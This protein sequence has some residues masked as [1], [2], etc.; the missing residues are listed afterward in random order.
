M[1]RFLIGLTCF[2]AI[3]LCAPHEAR[4]QTSA[5]AAQAELSVATGASGFLGTWNYLRADGE[6]GVVVSNA[7]EMD[8]RALAPPGATQLD[9]SVRIVA[10]SDRENVQLLLGWN[11]GLWG[12][13]DGAEVLANTNHNHFRRDQRLLELPLREG[14]HT[15]IL[16]LSAP[17]RGDW[18]L[19]VRVLDAGGRPAARDAQLL[20]ANTRQLDADAI[21]ALRTRAFGVT[22]MRD[23]RDDGPHLILDAG[24]AAGA[25]KVDGA[26]RL[27]SETVASTPREGA[28]EAPLHRDLTFRELSAA[29]DVGTGAVTTRVPYTLQEDRPLIAA[30]GELNAAA[31]VPDSARGPRAWRLAELRRMVREVE[32]DAAWR[33]LI[34]SEAH[35][36]ARAIARGRN[37]FASPR[38]YVRMGFMSRLDDTAQ[39]YEL[40]VPPAYRD[41]GDRRWPLLITLHGHSGNAGDYFRNTF[42]LSR[43][44]TQTLL[45]HGR[46][47]L[48]PTQGPM[49]V[50]A[51]TGRGQSQY[52]YAGEEDILEVLADVSSRFRI[53]PDRIYITGGSMGGTGAAYLPFRHP[54]LFAASAALAGYH[55]Q[56]VR[57]DTHQD[58]LAPIEQYLRA[59]RSDVDWAVN[60]QHLPM[61]LIRGTMDR[62]LAWTTR[63]AERLSELHYRFE[64]REP[65]SR[66]NVWTEN[67]A[68][69]A[70]FRW[71]APHRRVQRP[72]E[73]RFVTARERHQDAWWVQDVV[74]D[75]PDSFARVDARL[76]REANVIATTE[77]VDSFT[78]SPS[79]SGVTLHVRVDDDTLDGTCP[80]HLQRARDGHWLVVATTPMRPKHMHVSGPI[81]DVFNESLVF[82]VGTQ[83]PAHTWINEEVAREWA[84]PLGWTMQYPVVRDRDVTPEMIRGT[85]LVLIGPPSSNSVLA[86]M[87][88]RLPIRISANSIVVGSSTYSGP[89][90]GTV[91]VAPNPDAPDH[92]VLIIAGPTPLGT[93]RSLFLPDLLPDYVV[94]NESIAPARDTFALGGTGAL[95]LT[96]GFFDMNWALPAA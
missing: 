74:R 7:Q 80:M 53:D 85:T 57:S 72:R 26:I 59:E 56:R 82:V 9:L 61:L 32:S 75:A 13:L 38:G 31:Q 4:T 17:T 78:L 76:D 14:T 89:E 77:H 22:V 42:G 94:F 84:N 62:P 44:P 33:S 90:V 3:S 15:L 95:Y 50:V 19:S 81:R 24:F 46:H 34:A 18:T 40:F 49:F 45:G 87:N 25:V 47:G 92:S 30:F 28:F 68:D 8:V 51:P 39:P 27:G 55:D 16:H 6:L 54:G 69:G 2:A 10:R 36:L 23:L 70:I 11:A 5:L 60:A 88:D 93:W 79:A 1:R 66:H 12:E 63:L 67:Y 96:N 83:D 52:R 91:F 48:A 65:I 21:E 41:A 29:L 43:P 35:A 71:F 73:V 37:P 64:H 58:S 86:R 20:L